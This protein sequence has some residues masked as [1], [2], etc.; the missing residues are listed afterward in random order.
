MKESQNVSTERDFN[1]LFKKPL[2]VETQ[3]CS[4]LDIVEEE[5]Q[6]LLFWNLYS[7]GS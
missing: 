7:S 4:I 3:L 5:T 2:L 6:P 1:K